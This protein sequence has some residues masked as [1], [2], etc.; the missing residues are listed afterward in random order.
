MNLK[1]ADELLESAVRLTLN[2]LDLGDQDKAAAKAALMIAENIDAHT[3]KVYAMRWL[4]P[5]LLK[6][7]IE[8]GATPAA[9]AT[10]TR[11]SKNGGDNAAP[12]VSWLEQQ[13]ESRAARSTKRP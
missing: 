10:I 11:A 2:A 4:M 8:L 5:E 9:R 12:A 7:L 1:D 3:D 13:R 6:Y